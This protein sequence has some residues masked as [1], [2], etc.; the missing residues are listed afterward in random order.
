MCRIFY[1]LDQPNT[2]SKMMRF[3]K[4]SDHLEKNTP[5]L[6]SVSDHHSHPD[7][8]GLAGFAKGKWTV[9]K[10]PRIYKEVENL[11]E[12]VK[13]MAA[14]SLV[15]GHIRKCDTSY[16]I[17][18]RENTHPFYYRNHVFLH[19]GY[20]R[21]Y[22]A[23][24]EVIRNRVPVDLRQHIKGDTDSE[25]MFYLLLSILR[26]REKGVEPLANAVQELFQILA[27]IVPAYNANIIYANKE[28][29]LVTRFSHGP[30][31]PPS[32]YWNMSQQKG[33]LITSEPVSRSF[34]LIPKNTAIVIHHATRNT[35]TVPL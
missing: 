7:G 10:N 22:A 2:E 18:K 20:L 34:R 27:S 15:I 6:N 4:Q 21:E 32:L 23:Y 26:K 19:N 11:D 1:S 31:D 9:Y 29:S 35:Y 30:Q 28:Y 13:K 25:M 8:F 14:H 17:V 33:V 3:L 5:G 12:I 16:S 24:R